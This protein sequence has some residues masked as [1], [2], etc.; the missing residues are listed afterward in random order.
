MSE[1]CWHILVGVV[2][3]FADM[4]DAGE[5]WR[6]AEGERAWEIGRDWT[7]VA[8]S[9]LYDAR[10]RTSA[11]VAALEPGRDCDLVCENGIDAGDEEDRTAAD[12]PK[13]T[14]FRIESG[15]SG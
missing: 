15:G 8:H 7:G 10:A 11:G 9:W 4:V 12:R 14:V 3:R 2:D 6:G 1:K 5:P 13:H